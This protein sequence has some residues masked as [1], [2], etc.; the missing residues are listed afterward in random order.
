MIDTGGIL[1]RNWLRI[2]PSLNELVAE[3]KDGRKGPRKEVAVVIPTFNREQMLRKHL[4]KLSNQS[5]KDFDVVIVYS[6]TDRF[7]EDVSNLSI[8][9]IRRKEDIGS[10][11]GF[12]LGEKFC[13]Q[14]GY[15]KIILADDDCLPVSENLIDELVKNLEGGSGL[16]FP[17]IQNNEKN[18]GRTNRIIAQYGGLR[19][20]TLKAV[21]LTY[22]PFYQAGEDIELYY[23][24]IEHKVEVSFIDAVAFHPPLPCFLT[25][26]PRLTFYYHRGS[27]IFHHLRRQIYKLFFVSGIFL[28]SGL[29][30]SFVNR[31]L[32]GAV[33]DG[34]INGLALNFESEP[35]EYG[36]EPKNDSTNHKTDTFLI[37]IPGWEETPETAPGYFKHIFGMVVAILAK[38]PGRIH[39]CFGRDIL[40]EGRFGIGEIPLALVAR[41]A[42]WKSKTGENIISKGNNYWLSPIFAIALMVALPLMFIL[43]FL[44]TS[45]GMLKMSLSGISSE[46]YGLQER[47]VRK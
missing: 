26:P 36:S 6:P 44:L 2:G 25:L 4:M 8:V 24:I 3:I 5:F 15:E 28:W 27:L 45:Y 29:A 9:H 10:A 1:E 18:R 17:R 14:E 42:A 20:D 35:K 19:A 23:R 11:G 33:I 39:S 30:I 32:A 22:L 12:Y 34:S 7:I 46:G 31:R 40:I 21:G 38:L 41:S 43:G 47:S 16:V 37:Q 13:L